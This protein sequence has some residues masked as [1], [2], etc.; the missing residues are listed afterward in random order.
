MSVGF[1]EELLYHLVTLL[2][3]SKVIPNKLTS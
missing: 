2:I 1:S 3:I